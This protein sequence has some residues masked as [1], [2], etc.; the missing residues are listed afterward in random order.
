MSDFIL[1]NTNKTNK[2]EPN[3]EDILAN[4]NRILNRDKRKY[5]RFKSCYDS[6]FPYSFKVNNYITNIDYKDDIETVNKETI[7][8]EWLNENFEHYNTK[9]KKYRKLQWENYSLYYFQD[10]NMAMHFKLRWE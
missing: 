2:T 10:R 4:I 1:L 5:E 6:Y 3:M 7:I 9:N 8:Q